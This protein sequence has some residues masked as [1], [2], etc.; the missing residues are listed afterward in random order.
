MATDLKQRWFWFWISLAYLL[1]LRGVANAVQ[2]WVA[3]EHRAPRSELRS[4]ESPEQLVAYA[5]PR[6]RWRLDSGRLGGWALPL[7]WITSPEV[8]QHRLE[9]DDVGHGDCDDYHYWAAVLIAEMD[10]VD[11][12]YLLSSGLPRGGHTTAVFRRADRWWHLDY[13]LYPIDDPNDAPAKVARRYADVDTVP[14]YVFEHIE[15]R[16]RSAAIGPAGRVP[17]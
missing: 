12:V 8:F 9:Q 3:A 15:P 2:R 11:V 16:W 1:R 5:R 4:F 10:D 17:T 14:W 6:F 13:G 7:D